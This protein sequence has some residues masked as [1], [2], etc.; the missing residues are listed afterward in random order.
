MDLFSTDLLLS[1]HMF[2]QT[3]ILDCCHSAGADRQG[4]PSTFSGVTNIRQYRDPPH[5]PSDCDSESVSSL[6]R[7]QMKVPGFQGQ[8]LESHICLAA[9][10]S[11]QLA[12]EDRTHKPPRGYFTL[13]LTAVFRESEI[14]EL[15][16][17]SAISKVSA[18]IKSQN[19]TK[20]V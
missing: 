14:S 13:A 1:Y 3:L 12:G 6:P 17:M 7:G 11:S 18:K 19:M 16:Y 5:I 8:D 10:S 9:C 15:T 4:N 2:I 20:S